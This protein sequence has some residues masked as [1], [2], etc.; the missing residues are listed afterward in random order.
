MNKEEG[1]PCCLFHLYFYV[2]PH[3]WPV[4][5]FCVGSSTVVDLFCC[6]FYICTV[7]DVLLSWD[8][9]KLGAILG[10]F[11]MFFLIAMVLSDLVLLLFNFCCY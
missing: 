2:L 8:A 5:D 6:K 1:V 11:I 10:I 7:L 4:T 9:Q 3:L